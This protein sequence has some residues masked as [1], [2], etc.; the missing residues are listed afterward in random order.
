MSK[1]L[2]YINPYFYVIQARNILYEKGIIKNF[3]IS[4]PVISVGNLSLGGSGKTSLV[5]YLCE[6]LSSHCNMAV[7]SRGYKRKSKGTVI[8]M[9]KGKLKTD[10]VRAGDEPYLLGKIFEKRDIKIDIVVDENRKRGAEI[11]LKELRAN[12]ILLDDGFQHLKLKRNLDLVLLKKEDLE[13]TLFPFGRLREPLSSLKRADAIILTYQDYKPFDFSYKE[14]PVFKLY[15]KNWKILNKNLEEVHHFENKEFIAF[16]GLADNKQFFDTLE[17]LGL[18]I[19][20]RISF[21][22]HYHYKNFKLDPKENYIT[23]LKDGI[24]FDF[25]ENLYFLDFE[26]EVKGLIEFILKFLKM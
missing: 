14:K 12:L 2:D 23:T 25:K 24:K 17:K 26:I 5:R 9:E 13:D 7:L 15:R 3:K 21:P 16:C 20:K 6:N 8:V 19:K 11:A 22:D 18:K 10:W 1:L 4:V